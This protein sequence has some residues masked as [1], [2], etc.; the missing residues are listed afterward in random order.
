MIQVKNIWKTLEKIL[1]EENE[2]T[3]LNL[4]LLGKAYLF[5]EKHLK[6]KH[7]D[8]F[9]TFDSPIEINNIILNKRNSS[10]WRGQLKPQGYNFEY[11]HFSITDL[12]LQILIDNFKDRLISKKEFVNKLLYIHPFQTVT[13]EQ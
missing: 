1:I 10:L 6:T 3:E 9:L 8:L 5:K 4:K 11:M 7:N 2:F 12:H 13:V